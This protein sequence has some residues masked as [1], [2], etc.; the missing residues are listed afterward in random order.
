MIAEVNILLM[1]RVIVVTVVQSIVIAKIV[2]KQ[3]RMNLKK[4]RMMKNKTLMR[5]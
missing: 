2:G 3:K 1:M 4:K 5:L